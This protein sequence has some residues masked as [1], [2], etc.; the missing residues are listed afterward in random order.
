M[1]K[2][3]TPLAY[4]LLIDVESQAPGTSV[5][6]HYPMEPSSQLRVLGTTTSIA[7]MNKQTDPE[8]WAM[9]TNISQKEDTEEGRGESCLLMTCCVPGTVVVLIAV[10]QL[11]SNPCSRC[12]QYYPHFTDE[13][14]EA[15]QREVTHPMSCS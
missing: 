8:R 9:D 14:T 10:N 13:E 1:R 3:S 4:A 6:S 7:E 5:T 12:Y 15:Q 2:A 11:I